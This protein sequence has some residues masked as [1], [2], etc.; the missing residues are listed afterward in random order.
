M[1][2]ASFKRDQPLKKDAFAKKS[3]RKNCS[4]AGMEMS[5]TTVKAPQEGW[6]PPAE[7]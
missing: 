3:P 4:F 1:Q 7:T 2:K 6:K 5:G